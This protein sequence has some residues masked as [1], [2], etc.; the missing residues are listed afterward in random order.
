MVTA[1]NP[2]TQAL[3]RRKVKIADPN[4]IQYI[5]IPP[6]PIPL[7]WGRTIAPYTP[8]KTER[9]KENS[10]LVQTV[11]T[12]SELSGEKLI[13]GVCEGMLVNSR[14]YKGYSKD[15]AMERLNRIP[16]K[17][18]VPYG[19][20][21]VWTPKELVHDVCKSMVKLGY[22]YI[23]NLTWVW[24]LPNNTIYREKYEYSR[25]SHLTLYMFRAVDR[26]KN[27]ELRHQRSPDVVFDYRK[28]RHSC[29]KETYTTLETLLPQSQGKLMEIWGDEEENDR[30][31]W[32]VVKEAV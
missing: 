22:A 11:S 32:V 8:P 6:A 1:Y 23:E 28:S 4:E 19:F 7:S 29:P 16:I 3:V 12:M 15:T 14:W 9:T 27:I 21:F 10:A 30:P 26:S 18:L 20:V 17:N 31:G 2:S 24:K 25:K 5:K 13:D